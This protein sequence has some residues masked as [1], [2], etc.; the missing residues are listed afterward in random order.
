VEGLALQF[1]FERFAPGHITVVDDDAADRRV[2]EEVLPD[3]LDDEPRA[4]EMPNADFRTNLRA[5]DTR[6]VA[7]HLL[8][9][10]PIVGMDVIERAATDAAL[11]R[12]AED[13]LNRGTL[14]R[15]PAAGVRNHLD[16]DRVPDERA[17]PFL[18]PPQLAVLACQ[19]PRRPGE[20]AEQH[21][22]QPS[23]H[24]THDHE[25]VAAGRVD[26]A[27]DRRGVLVDLVGAND[28][29]R[30]RQA[31]WQVH[32][33]ELIREALLEDV[34][35]LGRRGEPGLDVALEC[36]LEIVVDRELHVA[37]SGQVGRDDRA[38]RRPDLDPQDLAGGDE[39]LQLA[40]DGRRLAARQIG[41]A[42]FADHRVDEPADHGLG[43]G[44]GLIDGGTGQVIRDVR[45]HGHGRAHDEER[46]HGEDPGTETRADVR[47]RGGQS[48]RSA[49][50]APHGVDAIRTLGGAAAHSY[51]PFVH[52][53]RPIGTIA[54]CPPT[55]GSWRSRA[56]L[57]DAT[58]G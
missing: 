54:L 42:G 43:R 33:E 5:G 46:G 25:H 53:G 12:V 1:V 32:L 45:R 44:H 37:Q 40:V 29:G 51:G 35:F 48:H 38:I 30:T 24:G 36:L 27:Q 14:I 2:V 13:P 11:G 31:D 21:E 9:P 57:A 47:Q 4:V 50:M 20:R 26:V 7:E 15:D 55:D 28:F 49:G 17:E 34:L 16:V 19:K 58:R 6:E 56:R 23:S 10:L 41:Q 8:S 22:Q 52:E 3:R 39:V 18:A